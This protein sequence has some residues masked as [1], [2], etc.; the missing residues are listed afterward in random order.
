MNA[1]MIRLLID[2]D[3]RETASSA[4]RIL[5]FTAGAAAVPAELDAIGEGGGGGGADITG[6]GMITG[7]G[8]YGLAG[9]RGSS[10]INLLDD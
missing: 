1:A 6:G 4:S 10:D 2:T 5:T 7:G 3:V 9:G 8:T